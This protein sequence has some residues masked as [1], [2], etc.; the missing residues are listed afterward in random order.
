M[1]LVPAKCPFC[2][3]TI[4]VDPEKE[5]AVC[6]YCKQPFIVEKAI[7]NYNT[8]IINNPN[9]DGANIHLDNASLV[10]KGKYGDITD[11]DLFSMGKDAL[12]VTS[13]FNAAKDIGDELIRRNCK[14]FRGYYVK[15]EALFELK[16][17]PKTS[18]G[19]LCKSYDLAPEEKT[20]KIKVDS[21]EQMV[22]YK[23]KIRAA[24]QILLMN[25][26]PV[27][28]KYVYEYIG[29]LL[30][31]RN[32][33]F[34]RKLVIHFHKNCPSKRI[35]IDGLEFE[36]NDDFYVWILQL[37]KHVV[38]TPA[39]ADYVEPN[40]PLDDSNNDQ[41]EL[42]YEYDSFFKTYHLYKKDQNGTTIYL[43]NK[44]NTKNG[45]YVATCV[46]GSYDCPEVWT[47]R[48]YRDFYLHERWWGKLFI[49]VYYAV[50][51]TI[52]K[53][54]G[55]SKWFNKINKA[56]LDKKVN[57]LYKKGYKNTKFSDKY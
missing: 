30:L 32:L 51:P 54:F 38:C 11:D 15:G 44:G 23:G 7:T 39:Y 57:K 31:T 53:I 5:A 6:E 19:L 18:L 20:E 29:S 49:K 12:F 28:D 35:Y 22:S 1:K 4:Q 24:I 36:G 55:K 42:F 43:K 3:G 13:D 2:G 25:N 41:I 47:L 27:M 33:Y 52:V 14:D 26:Y 16:A 50:S 34:Y 10:V 17:D 9:F 37:S 40:I 56:I 8:T 21:S 45:C 48:R 46:Y